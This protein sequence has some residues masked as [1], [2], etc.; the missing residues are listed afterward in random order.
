LRA[1][2]LLVIDERHRK[3]VLNGYCNHRWPHQARHHTPPRLIAQPGCRPARRRQVLGG[4][5]NEYES[6]AA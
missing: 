5:I 3:S 4:L 6:A 1:D 2:R